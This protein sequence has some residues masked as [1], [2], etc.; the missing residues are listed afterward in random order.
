VIEVIRRGA[1][2]GRARVAIFDFD[3]TLSLIRYGWME[4][5]LPLCVQ[6]LTATNCGESEVQLTEVAEEFVSRLTGKE[7]I[8]QMM[9]LA[10]AVRERGGTPLA[11]IEY[12]KMYLERLSQKIAGRLEGL[13]KR[14]VQ[15]EKYMVP[16]SRQFLEALV[17]K[18]LRLYLASGTD[19]SNVKEEA[20]LLNL[21]QYF[22]GRIYGAQDDLRSFSKALLVQQILTKTDTGAEEMVVFGDGYVEIEEVKKVGGTTVGVATAEPE[23]FQIDGWKRERLIRAG[24]DFM[25][26]NYLE[27]DNIFKTVFKV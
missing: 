5:M 20:H 16:G 10:D 21:S 6:Q 14:E 27:L 25:I 26:P 15:P 22:E 12:K 7:T 3:G 1:S 13:R 23:C 4:V 19:D 18:G 8:Y 24:A 2:A 11:P 9:A 17:A